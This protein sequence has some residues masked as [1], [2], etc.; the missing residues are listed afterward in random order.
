MKWTLKNKMSSRHGLVPM[1]VV[2]IAST[3]RPYATIE[4][5][6]SPDIVLKEQHYENI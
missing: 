2:D 4:F 3:K 5:G 6:L 1:T